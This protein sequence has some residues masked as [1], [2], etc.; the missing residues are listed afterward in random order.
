MS[1]MSGGP[2]PGIRRTSDTGAGSRAV[3]GCGRPC[4]LGT[5]IALSVGETMTERAT[6]ALTTLLVL[7]GGG[8][9]TACDGG[10]P[11][12]EP[13]VA[14]SPE[15]IEAAVRVHVEA[16]REMPLDGQLERMGRVEPRAS[17][18]IKAESAARVLAREV[19]RG[20][21][22]EADT[23]LYRLDGSRARI[24][25][26]RAKAQV[27]ARERDQAQAE[28]DRG[29]NEALR[30]RDSIADATLDRSVHA[31]ES[32]EAAA[33]L[34]RIG[35][36]AAAR[37]L[38]D[39]KIHAPFAGLVAEYHAEQGD[40]LAPGSP[41]VTLVDLTEVRLRVGLTAAELELVE[42]GQRL[43]VEF[44]ELGGER[45]EAEVHSISPLVDPRTGTYAAELRLDNDDERLLEGMLG[46]VELPLAG[47]EPSTNA[48]VLTIPRGAVVRRQGRYAV[49]VL[50]RAS[51]GERP[52]VR[53]RELTLGQAAGDRVI[54]RAGLEPGEEVVTTGIFALR[55]GAAVEIEEAQ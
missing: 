9:L 33:D 26:Q 19:E 36:R 37:S 25:Y 27:A 28:R 38:R 1:R 52:R 17:V 7:L 34:A 8:P 14:T 41:V 3:S 6:I 23:L 35:K 40:Y 50:E 29:R 18:V 55:E 30:A 49:W 53:A 24:E 5:A 21:R 31:H 4:G 15:Q 13:E 39:S 16:A 47:A 44:S 10:E 51:E 46:R 54:V 48:G 20:E 12:A 42:P 43:A 11:E 22:V 2:A 45:L 32:S